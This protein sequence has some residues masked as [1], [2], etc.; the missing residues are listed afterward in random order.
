MEKEEK[1]TKWLA[2]EMAKKG[3]VRGIVA[4]PV[5]EFGHSPYDVIEQPEKYKEFLAP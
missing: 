1:C 3:L 4:C 5:C 2:V